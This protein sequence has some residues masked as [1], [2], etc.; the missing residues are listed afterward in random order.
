MQSG[1]DDG[2]DETRVETASGLLGK[3]QSSGWPGEREREREREK[4]GCMLWRSPHH[5]L[6]PSKAAPLRKLLSIS[7]GNERPSRDEGEETVIR[8]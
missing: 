4:E 2:G 3:R 8:T 1:D 6:V 5:P 7:V